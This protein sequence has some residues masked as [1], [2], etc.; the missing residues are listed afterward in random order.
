MK[1]YYNINNKNIYKE[2]IETLSGKLGI[3]CFFRIENNCY[4]LIPKY[5]AIVEGRVRAEGG[6][7]RDEKIAAFAEYSI[8]NSDGNYCI[9]INGWKRHLFVCFLPLIFSVFLYPDRGQNIGVFLVFLFVICLPAV[10]VSLPWFY[11]LI[12]SIRILV[13]L[14]KQLEECK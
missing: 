2:S 12:K 1:F 13:G 5:S 7:V 10:F 4:G 9:I 8:N 14:K 11:N 6:L 3:Y